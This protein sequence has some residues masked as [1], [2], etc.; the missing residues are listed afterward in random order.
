VSS[1][2]EMQYSKL[3]GIILSVSLLRKIRETSSRSSISFACSLALR[4]IVASAS[5]VLPD[6]MCEFAEA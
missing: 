2:P 6:Q 1:A 5:A 3:I 4:L